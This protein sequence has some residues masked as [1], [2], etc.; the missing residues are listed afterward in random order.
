MRAS[1]SDIA[2]DSQNLSIAQGAP[3]PVPV[4]RV[5]VGMIVGGIVAYGRTPGLPGPYFELNGEG[6]QSAGFAH[7]PRADDALTPN[8]PEA[9]PRSRPGH[10]YPERRNSE[11]LARARS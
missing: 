10:R 7:H 3:V 2:G 8:R 1:F 4:E 11:P 6:K 9:L 5:S